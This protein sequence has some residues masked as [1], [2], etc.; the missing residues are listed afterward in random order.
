MTK[1]NVSMAYLGGLLL[2]LLQFTACGSGGISNIINTGGGASFS[3]VT[4]S[5]PGGTQGA[6]Y[7]VTLQASGGTQPYS[8]SLKSGSLPTGLSLSKTG[9]VTGTPTGQG[10]FN[11][12]VF[13]VADSSQATADSHALSLKINPK[14]VVITAA[15]PNS[16]VGAAYSATLQGTGGTAPYKWS[17]ESGALPAGLSLNTNTG[18]IT[19]VPTIAGTVGPFVFQLIDANL[20][21]ASSGKFNMQVIA[22]PAVLTTALPASEVGAAYSA[23]LQANGGTG[24]YTWSLKSGSLPGGLSLSAAGTIDGTPT[25]S[26]TFGPLVFQVIDTNSV[27]AL[28]S[29][30]SIQ[31]ATKPGVVTAFLPSDN[32][33]TAYSFNLQAQGG[34]FPYTWS[35]LSGT[36]PAGL[37]LNPAT[38]AITGT[39]T[40]PTLNSIVVQVTDAFAVS[41]ASSGINLQIYDALGCSA[42]VESKLGT[43]PY[44][45]LLKGFD[46]NGPVAIA[47]SL[48]TDGNGN[49]TGGNEDINRPAGVQ[50]IAI[51]GGS[52]TLG[53]D[54][55]GCLNLTTA[56]G[57][58][59]FRY[60]VG[61][62]NGAGA[63]TTG[64]IT[65]FDDANGTG[66]RG[67]GIL[68]LQDP[69]TFSASLG[70]MYAFLFTG[71]D[72]AGGHIGIVGS[73]SASG[74]AF[75]N[76]ALDFDDAGAVGTNLTGGSGAFT[77]ADSNGR[78][79]AS[80]TIGSFTLHTAF[81][82]INS[83]EAIFASTD[84]LSSSPIA[85][86]EA[87]ATSGP[88][89]PSNLSGNYMAHGVGLA[90]GDAPVAAI[91]TAAIDGVGAITGGT[92]FQ[93][94]AG[95]ASEWSVH[96]GYTV[97][98]N[99][100]RISFSGN[101]IAPVGYLVTGV[102]GVSAVL[103][104]NDF[105]ATSGVL[106]AQTSARPSAGK[107]TLGTEEDVDY[108]VVNQDGNFQI[109]A[110]K[111]SGT[112]DMNLGAAP[113]LEEN[114][115][116]YPTPY[117][118]GA[119][120]TG[121]FGANTVAVTN[122]SAVY[123]IDESPTNNHPSVTVL[124]K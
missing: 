49:I 66:T 86:G 117:T 17:L 25:T 84:P 44:A 92:L 121:I 13:E 34:T 63:F 79:T 56:G 98:A 89:A 72:S 105:P 114:Q 32:A 52:Y 80:F 19:G 65:E 116:V 29:H 41:A 14:V 27:N 106:S 20:N 45:F 57:T 69:S 112:Q 26:G 96:A 43:G 54:N 35:L 93:Y 3:V 108:S 99:S 95:N 82:L 23:A 28:S 76:L 94:Q 51:T 123:V 60:S 77:A 75:S 85:S 48:V 50:S 53:A 83:K 11:S 73:F 118:F 30:L 62:V 90:V 109:N 6:A 107:Y 64:Q 39:P 5:L 58:S 78:G 61:G 21:A 36:L 24:S 97:D 18:A 120:G 46:I 55:R 113:F 101:F 31:T 7:S 70:G 15:L 1:R 100:G 33:G 67:S 2:L 87:F 38:G 74:G 124:T 91:A 10:T 16:E 104:G 71:A 22:A 119:D 115:T 110:G 42:G 8:W 88:F 9:A 122:G 81:Y 40:T 37:F 103:T 12:L 59:G 47:G 102:P 4:A 111:F 68:R